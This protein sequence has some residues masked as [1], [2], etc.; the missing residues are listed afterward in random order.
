MFL[1]VVPLHPENKKMK[2]QMIAL[3]TPFVRPDV[4]GSLA[5]PNSN[6]SFEFNEYYAL[7]MER[8]GLCGAL[9][10]NYYERWRYFSISHILI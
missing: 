1:I 10:I 2:K 4:Y 5:V 7:I 8:C 9:V 6:V 3:H